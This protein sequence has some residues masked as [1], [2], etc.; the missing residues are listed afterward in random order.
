MYS[1]K[2]NIEYHIQYNNIRGARIATLDARN[3]EVNNMIAE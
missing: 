3:Y 1:Q 2:W